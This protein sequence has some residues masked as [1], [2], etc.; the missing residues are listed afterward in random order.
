MQVCVL[1][2]ALG[3]C[4]FSTLLTACGDEGVLQ[5]LSLAEEAVELVRAGGS[6]CEATLTLREGGPRCGCSHI[7]GRAQ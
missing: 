6:S 4:N 2:L 7:L 5:G 1:R 3:Y